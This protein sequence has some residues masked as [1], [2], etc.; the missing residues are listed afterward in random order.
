MNVYCIQNNFN[1]CCNLCSNDE[2]FPNLE[3]LN[4]L[5]KYSL[6]FFNLIS[7]CFIN[8][9]NKLDHI[10]LLINKFLLINKTFKNK[11]L[12]TTILIVYYLH[13]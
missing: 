9:S 10:K 11:K 8:S 2:L 13:P 6:L 5:N 4:L 7:N 3:H 1:C 12:L